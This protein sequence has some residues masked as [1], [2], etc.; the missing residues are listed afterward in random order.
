MRELLRAQADT[1][2][3]SSRPGMFMSYLFEP[4]FG[5]VDLEKSEVRALGDLDTAVTLTT[6]NDI[7]A[8]TAEIVFA[9]PTE[10]DTELPWE[11]SGE[12]PTALRPSPASWACRSW[13]HSERNQ[14]QCHTVQTPM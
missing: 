5:M 10:I 6:P 11:N 12:C 2:G 8:L 1:E 7:G 9:E 4:E 14:L 3:S 13:R